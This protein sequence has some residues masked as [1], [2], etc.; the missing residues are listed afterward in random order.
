MN[1]KLAVH[2]AQLVITKNTPYFDEF[3]EEFKKIWS[4]EEKLFDFPR[5]DPMRVLDECY[6]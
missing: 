6:R 4:T 3:T 2:G 5:N 1:Q